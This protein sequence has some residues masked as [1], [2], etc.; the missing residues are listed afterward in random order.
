VPS[1]PGSRPKAYEATRVGRH[2]YADPRW[3]GKHGLRLRVLREEPLCGECYKAGHVVPSAEV[4]HI[5]PHK[6]DEVLFF[7]R[8]NVQGLCKPCHSRKTRRGA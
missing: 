2:L 6:G 3:K 8:T 1:T 5:V 4:D 7:E